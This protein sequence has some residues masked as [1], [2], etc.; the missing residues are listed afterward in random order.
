M[1]STKIEGKAVRYVKEILDDCP[2]LSS[3]DIKDGD[4]EI[5]WDGFVKIFNSEQHT[6]DNLLGRVFVQIKGKKVNDTDLINENI[7]YAAEV[8]DLH[9]Y[10]KDGGIIYMVVYIAASGERHIFYETLTVVKLKDYLKDIKSEQKNKSLRLRSL[11]KTA[12][13]IETVFINFYEDAKKT[14]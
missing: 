5:S 8:S 13:E 4:K 6:K 3:S 1:D 7:S 14:K 2:L 12:S 10:Q 11:P 9:N